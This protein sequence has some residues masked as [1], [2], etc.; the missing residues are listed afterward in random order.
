MRRLN[1][2]MKRINGLS[3]NLERNNIDKIKG[4]SNIEMGKKKV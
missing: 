1:K 4:S 3:L 2:D